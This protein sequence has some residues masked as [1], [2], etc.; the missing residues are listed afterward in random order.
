MLLKLPARLNTYRQQR[1][2]PAA[3]PVVPV[4]LRGLVTPFAPFPRSPPLL[5][6]ASVG[7]PAGR[8][9]APGAQHAAPPSDEAR[10]NSCG[11][12][13]PRRPRSSLVPQAE[14]QHGP[15]RHADVDGNVVLG[16]REQRPPPGTADAPVPA[17]ARG[18][19]GASGGWLGGRRRRRRG[20]GWWWW[21]CCC[22][23]GPGVVRFVFA[24]VGLEKGEGFPWL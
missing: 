23:V 12:L 2:V 24:V 15:G 10:A 17:A 1:C 11:R 6:R 9:L 14:R 21:C 8:S 7:R 3:L 19:G 13:T 5:S 22:C 16:G 18:V 4:P 20:S